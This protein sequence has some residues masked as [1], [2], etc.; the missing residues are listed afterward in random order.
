MK[1]SIICL[2]I[3]SFTFSGCAFLRDTS[4]RYDFDVDKAITIAHLG[5]TIAENEGWEEATII[6]EHLDRFVRLRERDPDAI[7]EIIEIVLNRIDNEQ[8][9][10]LFETYRDDLRRVLERRNVMLQRSTI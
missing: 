6:R 7:L 3:L 4:E 8:L 2:I 5:L 9:I 10:D 1:Y